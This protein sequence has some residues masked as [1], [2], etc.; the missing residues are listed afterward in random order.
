LEVSAD[1]HV[2]YRNT[3]V[4]KP[5][6]L[7]EVLA[8]LSRQTV[9]YVWTVEPVQIEERVTI[10]VQ[11][12][13]EVS[14]PVPV[15]VVTP[16]LIDLSPLTRPGQT[17]QV[18]VK[19]ANH[20]LIAWQGVN[21]AFQDN[22]DY[23]LVPLIKDVGVIPA[24]SEVIV[25]VVARRKDST[26]ALARSSAGKTQHSLESSVICNLFGW[27]SGWYPCGPQNVNNST[28]MQG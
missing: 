1:K 4:L 27:I 16:T 14:V 15:I 13:F 25:P 2:S 24:Q 21:I 10:S 11:A 3:I 20:G 5:G 28:S 6:V 23:E 26:T 22:P 7:N 19:V 18:D 17:L 12:I 9:T 8:F